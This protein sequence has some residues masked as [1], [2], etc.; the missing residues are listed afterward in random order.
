M[1]S[2]NRR[3]ILRGIAV[4]GLG[5]VM[6]IALPVSAKPSH[7]AKDK[8]HNRHD[9]RR[10]DKRH[11]NR[12]DDRHDNRRDDHWDNRNND[13]RNN[14]NRN[15][16]D[17]NG[18]WNKPQYGGNNQAKSGGTGTVV[19]VRSNQSVDVNIGGKIYNV[20]ATSR[21]PYGISRGDI[22]RV[23]GE[24]YGTNDFRNARVTIIRNR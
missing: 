7:H 2:V 8:K 9:N 3:G 15:D 22:V 11:D 12:R 4:V 21:L 14:D 1:K 20:Y 24:R 19:R 13:N 23:A 6:G 5:A 10:N 16:N 17:R 18:G